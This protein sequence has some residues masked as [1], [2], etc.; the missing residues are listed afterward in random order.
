[1]KYKK[2]EKPMEEKVMQ[3]RGCVNPAFVKKHRINLET[4]PK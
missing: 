2:D 1:V 3:E 4:G